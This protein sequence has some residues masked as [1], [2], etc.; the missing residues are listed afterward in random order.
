MAK[1]REI[2]AEETRMRNQLELDS[3][4]LSSPPPT[5]CGGI[6]SNG[7]GNYPHNDVKY[8]PDINSL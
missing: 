3:E 7:Y 8:Y 5:P 4:M 6:I 1:S 2:L